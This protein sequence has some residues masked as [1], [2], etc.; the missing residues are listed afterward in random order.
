MVS[1]MKYHNLLDAVNIIL[2]VEQE[3]DDATRYTCITINTEYFVV[4]EIHICY[5]QYIILR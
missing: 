2:A 3:L 4:V 1:H 5:Q